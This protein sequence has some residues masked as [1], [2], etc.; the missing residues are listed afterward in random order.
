MSVHKVRITGGPGIGGVWLEVDGEPVTG[1]R[2]FTVRGSWARGEPCEVQ[3]V[4]L[5]EVDVDVDAHV[6]ETEEILDVRTL[7]AP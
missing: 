5:A 2:E 3:L 7:G 4:L 6:I 1:C